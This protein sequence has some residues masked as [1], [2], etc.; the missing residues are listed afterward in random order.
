MDGIIE[1]QRFIKENSLFMTFA[2]EIREQSRAK[3]ISSIESGQ[4]KEV[5]EWAE[6]F[7]VSSRVLGRKENILQVIF[8]GVVANLKKPSS[9]SLYRIVNVQLLTLSINEIIKK[10]YSFAMII[11]N[12]QS[13]SELFNFHQ[14]LEPLK[15][16]IRVA[17]QFVA[18]MI[19]SFLTKPLFELSSTLHQLT[20]TQH[21]FPRT[22]LNNSSLKQFAQDL[23]S[24][25]SPAILHS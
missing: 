18:S 12:S 21:G 19:T 10:D 2:K 6:N 22:S 16:T 25:S 20:V 13:S 7:M 9:K 23:H 8:E 11:N 14:Y 15:S 3:V 24:F 1:L 5:I 17:D 4:Y